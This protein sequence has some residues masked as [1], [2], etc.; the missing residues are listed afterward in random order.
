MGVTAVGPLGPQLMGAHTVAVA[1]AG[2]GPHREGEVGVGMV[3]VVRV[4]Q[5]VGADAIIRMEGPRCATRHAD[6][7]VRCRAPW[8]AFGALYIRLIWKTFFMVCLRKCYCNVFELTAGES[9][10]ATC[11]LFEVQA[12]CCI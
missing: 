4:A 2:M 6:A 1:R 3:G 11:P 12:G 5:A 7:A 9:P 10:V 8:T